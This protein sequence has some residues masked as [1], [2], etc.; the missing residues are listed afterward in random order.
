MVA[1]V[2]FN[3]WEDE[4]MAQDCVTLLLILC[5]PKLLDLGPECSTG[6]AR[7]FCEIFLKVSSVLS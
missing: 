7:E 2:L 3:D 4:E 6:N 5:A 1:K